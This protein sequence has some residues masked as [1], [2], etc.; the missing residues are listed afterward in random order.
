M[1]VCMY[2]CMYIGQNEREGEENNSTP[3]EVDEMAKLSIT[4]VQHGATS[5]R[6]TY[7]NQPMDTHNKGK[8]KMILQQYH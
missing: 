4:K 8:K 5:C 6:D 7:G 3:E 1:Y 2:V